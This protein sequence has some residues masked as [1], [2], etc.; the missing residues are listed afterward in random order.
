M[1]RNSNLTS[2]TICVEV[3]EAA[4]LGT[5]PLKIE[6]QE[7]AGWI[8]YGQDDMFI[9]AGESVELEASRYP[10][11]ISSAN[12]NQPVVFKVEQIRHNTQAHLSI[13]DHESQKSSSGLKNLAFTALNVV[14][15]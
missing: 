13:D 4:N 5:D 2:K 3:N 14:K 10:V 6:M 1:E 7:G 9:D 12:R 11:V 8:T 15:S